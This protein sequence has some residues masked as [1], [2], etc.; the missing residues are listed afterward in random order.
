MPA[1]AASGTAPLRAV[2]W[3]FLLPTPPDHPFKRLILLG[4]PTGVVERA[5][6]GGLAHETATT[7]P[8]DAIADAIAAYADARETIPA[9]AGALS[10]GGVLYLEIDR[11]HRGVRA[12]TPRRIEAVLRDFGIA[13]CA[14][15]ALEPNAREP[16]AY[17]PLDAP[18]VMS[19]HRRAAFGDRTSRRIAN[20]VRQSAVRIGG[21]TVAALDRPYAVVAVRGR[22]V[23][24][25]P[26]TLRH[27]EVL[28]RLA[29]ATH[30]P[31]TV[32]LT[33]GGDR[34]LLFPFGDNGSEP[35]GVVK[36]PKTEALI[37]RTEN[38]QIQMATLRT[39]LP[40]ALATAIP[41]PLGTVRMGG[42]VA[43][44]ERF[45][46]GTSI[47][48]RAMD[49]RQ[50][51]DDKIADLDRAMAWL[52]RFHRATEVRRVTVRESH[53]ALVAAPVEW[54]EREIGALEESALF[55]AVR[56]R[57]LALGDRT[58]A[59]SR[60]HRDFAAWNVLRAR[61]QIAVVDWEGAREG[62]GAFDAVHFVTTWLYSVRLASGVN[63]ET[64]CVLDLLEPTQHLDRAAAAA[65]D[66]LA[67]TLRALG[68]DRELAPFVIVLHRIELAVRRSIQLRLHSGEAD[69]ADS[70]IEVRIVRALAQRAALLFS[71]HD[72]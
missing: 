66:A 52:S 20:A 42:T 48:A 47:A 6:L 58:I 30:P 40:S 63:D 4:G 32:T 72:I 15:Y 61:D 44:C 7:L 67:R 25:A 17:V 37:D 39:M 24:A 50:S 65:R 3:R 13:V 54:Y 60:Q 70:T 33:Y 36:V 51:L 26:G 43:A 2:D 19:W 64:R 45:M 69:S 53:D 38:E 49:P 8:D 12:S 16:R 35:T 56:S 22:A 21:T 71:S 27:P 68:V 28:R 1:S 10:D 55:S 18:R 34:V 5:T 46:P 23:D 59:I 57:A 41:E 9:I 14:F 29:I 62:F 31:A 11:A